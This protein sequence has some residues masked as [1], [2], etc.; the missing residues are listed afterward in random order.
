[1]CLQQ[2]TCNAVYCLCHKVSCSKYRY[3]SSMLFATYKQT[4][5]K[6]EQK[7]KK[8]RCVEE[9]RVEDVHGSS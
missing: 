1:M 2:L 4:L 9:D 7:L 3:C 5:Q 6:A 8:E